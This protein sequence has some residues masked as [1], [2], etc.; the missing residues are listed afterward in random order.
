MPRITDSPKYK[1]IS[2][3]AGDNVLGILRDEAR[4]QGSPLTHVVRQAFEDWITCHA[5]GVAKKARR[6]L[7][8]NNLNTSQKLAAG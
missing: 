4:R 2:F 5:P 6:R 8:R 3:R 7:L 1:I